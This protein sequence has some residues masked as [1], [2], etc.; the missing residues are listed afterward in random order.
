MIGVRTDVAP[1]QLSKVNPPMAPQSNAN[2]NPNRSLRNF[3]VF[4][5]SEHPVEEATFPLSAVFNLKVVKIR[6]ETTPL[7]GYNEDVNDHHSAVFPSPQQAASNLYPY[8][9]YLHKQFSCCRTDA[10]IKLI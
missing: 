10:H 6:R 7:L 4:V 9:R 3:L 5:A 2:I 8:I 1:K